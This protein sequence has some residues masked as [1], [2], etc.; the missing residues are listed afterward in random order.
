MFYEYRNGQMMPVPDHFQEKF[1]TNLN[2]WLFKALPDLTAWECF[3]LRE[4]ITAPHSAAVWNEDFLS[5][6]AHY[7]NGGISFYY[8]QRFENFKAG[9][10]QALK[11]IREDHLET[12]RDS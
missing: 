3:D 7:G 2:N 9:V 5:I 6:V 11:E 1:K 12:L 4:E 8:D 10:E